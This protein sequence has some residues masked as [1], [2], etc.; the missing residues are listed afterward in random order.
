[1]QNS[2]T[3]TKNTFEKKQKIMLVVFVLVAVIGLFYVKWSPYYTKAFVAASKH[4]IGNSII[5]GKAAA[6]PEPSWAA[7]WSYAV[8]YFK[9]VWKAVVLGLLL[10]SLVQVAIPRN[11][12]KKVFG[13]T[14][15]TS[16][17]A[18]G[19]A[20]LPAMM[21]SCCAA[22]VTVGLRKSS[23]SVS[24]AMAFFLAN[25]VLNPATIIFMG[26]VL[27]WEFA[28][29]RIIMGIVMV[30]GVSILA[31]RFIDEKD[32]EAADSLIYEEE[33]VHEDGN[34][35]VRWLHA[36]WQLIIDTIPAYLIVVFLLG[37]I[38]AWLFPTIGGVWA[39]GILAIIMFAITGTLFA[40]PTAA[41][42]PIVQTLMTFGL[43]VGPAAALIITLPA[44]SVPSLLIIKRVF[45]TR[46]LLFV[47]VA[48]ILL[49]IAGG[50][51]AMAIL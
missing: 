18:A 14:S 25:P 31:S 40:I 45:P 15:I 22:P 4:S 5:T 16:T 21:C 51:L 49:G 28:I 32:K 43:G 10:G 30:L 2:T 9:S 19:A 42:I 50:V 12:I 48:V 17:A 33:I 20:A 46:V 8:V 24:S 27:S 11:W 1:M 34:F 35:L 6:A 47:T 29:F 41:E 37:G 39:E 23:A 38:R 13:R 44:V 3:N 26:F 7:A 36:L